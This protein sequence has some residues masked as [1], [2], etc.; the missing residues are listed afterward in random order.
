MEDWNKQIVDINVR[1]DLDI[2][3]IIYPPDAIWA[4]MAN[5]HLNSI[6]RL[7]TLEEQHIRD[8]AIKERLIAR[9]KNT[10]TNQ[11]RMLAS[12]LNRDFK[13]IRDGSFSGN[14]K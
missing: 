12:L 4:I 10:I 14:R 6:K 8:I 5:I 9:A 3:P 1:L 13:S 11:S 7:I 2:P